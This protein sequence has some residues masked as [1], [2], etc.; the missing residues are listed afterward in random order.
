MQLQP[1]IERERFAQLIAYAL[2]AT[3]CNHT[4]LADS[5]LELLREALRGQPRQA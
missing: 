4:L 2:K 5:R 3:G 1:V